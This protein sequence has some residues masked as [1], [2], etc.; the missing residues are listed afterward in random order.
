MEGK[1]GYYMLLNEN[2]S[3]VKYEANKNYLNLKR[4]EFQVISANCNKFDQNNYILILLEV[5]RSMLSSS[6]R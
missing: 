2:I 1:V 3:S 4:K 5:L 6:D